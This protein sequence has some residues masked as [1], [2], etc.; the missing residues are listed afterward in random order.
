MGFYHVYLQR[1]EERWVCPHCAGSRMRRI[2]L[3]H[4]GYSWAALIRF[5]VFAWSM[6]VLWFTAL[7]PRVTGLTAPQIAAMIRSGE[8]FRGH[9]LPVLACS[10]L[11]SYLCIAFSVRNLYPS[12][13]ILSAYRCRECGRKTLVQYTDSSSAEAEG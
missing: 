10:T 12:R 5:T 6:A 8:A 11:I 2:R 3:W 13:C 9:I 1:Q 7:L 4:P